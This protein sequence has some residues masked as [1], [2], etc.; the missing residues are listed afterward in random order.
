[1][2]EEKLDAKTDAELGRM[3]RRTAK[4]LEIS[5]TNSGVFHVCAL[6][7][8]HTCFSVN[9]T[10]SQVT[11]SGVTWKGELIGD[12]VVTIERVDKC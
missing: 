9:A 2:T 5:E 11:E 8:I 10:R 4:T 7:M 1:M 12:W 3:V 6:V